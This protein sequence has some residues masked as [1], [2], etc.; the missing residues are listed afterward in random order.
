MDAAATKIQA[1]FRG[2]GARSEVQA[3]NAERVKEREELAMQLGATSV[4]T[5]VP[6]FVC[7]EPVL[8]SVLSAFV[9]RVFFLWAELM[10]PTDHPVCLLQTRTE[11]SRDCLVS[12]ANSVATVLYLLSVANL[13]IQSTFRGRKGRRQAQEELAAK[14]RMADLEVRKTHLV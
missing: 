3:I 8:A 4:R 10:S 12:A 1:R 6:F 9:S 11:V 2:R 5:T 14:K 13:Q 7:P